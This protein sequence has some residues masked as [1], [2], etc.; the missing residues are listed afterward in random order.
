MDAAR[1][2]WGKRAAEQAV[3]QEFVRMEHHENCQGSR[4]LAFCRLQVTVMKKPQVT[5]DW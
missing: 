4:I 2:V 3:E 5:L 1:N